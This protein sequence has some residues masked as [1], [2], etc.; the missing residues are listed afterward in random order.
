[1]KPALIVE[2][3]TEPREHPTAIRQVRKLSA[4]R[5]VTGKERRRINPNKG[6][7][8]VVER[9]V[10]IAVSRFLYPHLSRIWNPYSWLLEK[11][12]GLAET[13]VSPLHW[14]GNMDPIRVLLLSD[15]HCGIF[16]KPQSL[17]D[18]LRAL[19][20][21]Q[22]DLVA[23]SGD[24]VTG[25]SNE[26]LP[27]LEALSPL[28]RAP[29]GAWFC[30]GNHDYYDGNPEFIKTKLASV[31]ITT[32]K[33]ESVSIHH[34]SGNFVLGGVDDLILGKPDWDRLCDSHGPPHLLL[35]HN[36]DHFYEAESRGI[37][38]TLSGHTHGGQIRLP[39]GSPIIR[40]SRYCLDEG[41]YSYRSSTLLVSRGL[42]SVGLP[43]RWGADPEALLIEILPS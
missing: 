38:L 43:W 10:D 11:R 33:N 6:V 34:G 36:P 40:H 14:P 20:E 9:N 1:M 32:L 24:I 2:D 17:A 37:P 3:R 39:K 5:V 8:K 16:L 28:A 35:A 31:G 27:Y 22:P 13:S 19:M 12:F 26:L 25:H 30:F 42:G 4:P 23:I 29:Q 15:I 18:I 7:I 41:A 21:L